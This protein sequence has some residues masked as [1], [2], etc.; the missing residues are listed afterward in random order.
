MIKTLK[1][2]H[3]CTSHLGFHQGLFSSHNRMTDRGCLGLAVAQCTWGFLFLQRNGGSWL[4][5]PGQQ[6]HSE[7]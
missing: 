2:V 1:L 6:A 5:D 7:S 4:M 3:R